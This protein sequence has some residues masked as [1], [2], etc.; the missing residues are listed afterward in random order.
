MKRFLLIAFLVSGS[1]F[2]QNIKDLKKSAIRDAKVVSEASIK[3]DTRTLIKYTH[4]KIIQK[5]GKLKTM[6]IIDDVF[7][8]MGAQNI[9]ILSSKINEI[10]E[11]KKEKGEYRCLVTNTIKMDLNGR[12]VTVNSS[13]FGFY[14]KQTKIWSFIE[15]SKLFNDPETQEI[16]PDFKTSIIIPEDEYIEG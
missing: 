4:P 16:F 8:M 10:G 5:H 6:E 2:S 3:Q 1:L 11:I 7:G 12:K 15:S 14:N 9:K 13:L